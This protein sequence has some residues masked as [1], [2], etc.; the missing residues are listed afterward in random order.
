[1]KLIFLLLFG[2]F[3]KICAQNHTSRIH[4]IEGTFNAL[5]ENDKK[6]R[7]IV[8]EN[9][10][11]APSNFSFWKTHVQGIHHLEEEGGY[12]IT[13]SA[14]G[15]PGYFY[16][17]E[18]FKGIEFDGD[19][20]YVKVDENYTH[21]GGIQIYDGIMAVGNERFSD[22][23]FEVTDNDSSTVKFFDIGK[24]SDIKE[25]DKIQINRGVYDSEDNGWEKE[26]MKA[27]GVGL[28]KIRY[29]WLLAVRGD[30]YVD[31]YTLEGNPRSNVNQEFSMIQR[32]FFKDKKA[33]SS[34]GIQLFS[35]GD[36]TVHMFALNSGK[37]NRV[38]L[39][40]FEIVLDGS[41]IK[42][43]SDPFYCG[44]LL[45]SPKNGSLRNGG[46]IRFVPKYYSKDSGQY[47]GEFQIISTDRNVKNG[48]FRINEIGN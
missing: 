4:D 28:V 18:K 25:L 2:C 29:T 43:L 26:G 21:P 37:K 17:I 11:K 27:S 24:F 44:S 46:A 5:A 12:I 33:T 6:G 47:S 20:S 19:I 36:G 35:Q 10:K 14:S 39:Y 22:Y 16:L 30:G 13:G 9:I 38:S 31:F 32:V 42:G 41:R 15:N 40:K 1:M 8:I 7:V 23:L 34:Q 48:K 3:S 45:F